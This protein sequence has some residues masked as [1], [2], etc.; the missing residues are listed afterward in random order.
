MKT[1]NDFIESDDFRSKIVDVLLKDG[2]AV[3]PTDTIYGLSAMMSSR[4]GYDRIIALKQCEQGRSFLLLASNTKMVEKYIESWGSAKGDILKQAWPAPL[5]AILPANDLCPRWMG[6]NIAFR[7]PDFK[8]LRRL[9]SDLDE[10]AVSTSVNMSGGPPFHRLEEISK[11]F[12]GSVD[13]IARSR[14]TT[15]DLPSTIVDFTRSKPCVLR[16]GSYPW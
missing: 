10:P 4:I 11:V 12:G 14:R 3:L 2:V 7:V 15:Q 8:P 9:V 5:T 1:T 13:I 6:P 16:Q